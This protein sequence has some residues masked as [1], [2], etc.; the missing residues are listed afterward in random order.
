[1]STRARHGPRECCDVWG[2]GKLSPVEFAHA[3]TLELGT[4]D[5]GKSWLWV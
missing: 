5:S 4:V 1:L 2:Q 3:S